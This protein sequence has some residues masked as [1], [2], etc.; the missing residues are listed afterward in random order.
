M[1][2]Y[3]YENLYVRKTLNLYR[4]EPRGTMF[5][6]TMIK[7]DKRSPRPLTINHCFSRTLNRTNKSESPRGTRMKNRIHLEQCC[8]VRRA[9]KGPNITHVGLEVT[10]VG[11]RCDEKYKC[12]RETFIFYRVCIPEHEFRAF[13]YFD[14]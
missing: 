14:E 12:H 1:A 8:F 5:V 2:R 7:N 9:T 3:L 4:N 10:F 11:N 6:K 13:G